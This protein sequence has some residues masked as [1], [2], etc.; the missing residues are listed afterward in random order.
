MATKKPKSKD[1]KL[2]RGKAIDA[3]TGKIL[4]AISDG[5]LKSKARARPR[6]KTLERIGYGRW[7]VDSDE[8]FGPRN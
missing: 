6:S 1:M 3:R 5:L 2:I 4:D 7:R 8:G